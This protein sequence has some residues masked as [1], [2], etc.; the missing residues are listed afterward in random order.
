VAAVIPDGAGRY[1]F[2]ERRGGS[3]DGFWEMPGGKVELG[4]SPEDALVRE[5]REEL[6]LAVL[7]RWCMHVICHQYPRRI[8]RTVVAFW[9]CA[10]VP[11]LREIA[12][13]ATARSALLPSHRRFEVLYPGE[14]SAETMILPTVRQFLRWAVQ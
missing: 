9:E 3:L 14:V 13:S 1:L 11:N 6:E 2:G 8:D 4:E 10:P 5:I 7:P 12:A